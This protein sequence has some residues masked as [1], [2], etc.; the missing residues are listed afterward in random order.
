MVRGIT[1]KASQT[2]RNHSASSLVRN[3][4][5]HHQDSQFMNMSQLAMGRSPRESIEQVNLISQRYPFSQFIKG[6]RTEFAESFIVREYQ[7]KCRSARRRMKIVSVG[8]GS[9]YAKVPYC[10]VIP[11]RNNT[12]QKRS[13]MLTFTVNF[14]TERRAPVVLVEQGGHALEFNRGALLNLGFLIARRLPSC[15]IVI[16]HDVDLTPDPTLLQFYGLALDAPLHLNGPGQQTK[17][18]FPHYYGG[19]VSMSIPQFEAVNGFPT[20][21]WGWGG[22]DDALFFRVAEVYRRTFRPKHGKVSEMKHSRA[23]HASRVAK[24]FT[25]LNQV[26][27]AYSWRSDGLN[28]F[29]NVSKEYFRRESHLVWV[30]AELNMIPNMYA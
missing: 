22:E 21:F 14:F 27:D 10:V 26:V 3:L 9:R 13:A 12:S 7:R 4:I 30:R 1:M 6:I 19:I 2:W 11:F 25:K 24:E 18:P 29:P 28:N 20:R 5:P 8:I 15:Q 17:Y 23:T 16:F